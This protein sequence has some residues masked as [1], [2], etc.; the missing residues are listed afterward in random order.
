MATTTQPPTKTARQKALRSTVMAKFTMAISGLLMGAFLLVHMYGN[1]K[2]FAGKTADGQWA[3]DVYAEHLRAMGEPILPHGGILWIMR[4]VLL[5]TIIAHFASAFRLWSRAKKAVGSGKRY[6]KGGRVQRSYASYTMRW[7]G[8]VILLFV[9][10]HILQ[11]TTHTI[12]TWGEANTPFERM[13][14]SFQNPLV[15]AVYV[16]AILAV[17]LHLMHGIWSAFATLGANSGAKARQN[18]HT[19]AV[20]IA[21]VLVVGFLAGPFFIFFG[22]ITL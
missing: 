1:L 22:G 19:L 12:N 3:F 5:V 16:L 14:L 15:L 4:V 8:V 17:G 20:V 2:V 18:L 7:G 21:A 11:F 10:F 6:A 9:V 13:V